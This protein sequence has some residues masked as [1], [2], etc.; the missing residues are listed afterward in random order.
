MCVVC[1]TIDKEG[2]EA[3]RKKTCCPN[4][5]LCQLASATFADLCADEKTYLRHLVS[6]VDF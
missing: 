3:T 2:N 6:E 5:R 1:V 4:M